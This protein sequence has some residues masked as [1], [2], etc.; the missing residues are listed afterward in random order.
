MRLVK[1]TITVI[2][3]M[4]IL[5]KASAQN[6]EAIKGRWLVD[7]EETVTRMNA[8]E[9]TKISSLPERAQEGLQKSLTG[10]EFI[11][12]A[13]DK[14]KLRLK[15]KD[16]TTKEVQGTWH[17]DAASKELTM[18]TEDSERKGIVTWAGPNTIILTYSPSEGQGLVKLLCLTRS[19]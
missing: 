15:A 6:K 16:S 12:S 14:L 3:L 18:I 8:T 7:V 1:I 13:Q 19:N 2:A 9:S 17:Y 5:Q 11:F 4:M 10:R